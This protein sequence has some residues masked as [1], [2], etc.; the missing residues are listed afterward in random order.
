MIPTFSNNSIHRPC[1]YNTS[2]TIHFRVTLG[3]A[4]GLYWYYMLYVTMSTVA[5]LVLHEWQGASPCSLLHPISDVFPL[6]VF[7]NTSWL[8]KQ[9]VILVFLTVTAPASSFFTKYLLET[10]IHAIRISHL[11]ATKCLYYYTLPSCC[12]VYLFPFFLP[13][14]QCFTMIPQHSGHFFQWPPPIIQ[15]AVSSSYSSYSPSP[16]HYSMWSG[17]YSCSSTNKCQVT[18]SVCCPCIHLIDTHQ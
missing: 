17:N 5:V 7:K 14:I 15:N 6:F 4:P 11:L 8:A 18:L 10:P 9:N 13:P 3:D 1:W 16:N 2:C 12:R